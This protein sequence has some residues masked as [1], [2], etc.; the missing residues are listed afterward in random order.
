M[1]LTVEAARELARSLVESAQSRWAHVQAVGRRAEDLCECCE[2]AEHVA[3]AAWLH[4]IGYGPTVVDTGLHA[5]DGA[6]WLERF[7][8]PPEV[9]QLVGW[10]TGAGFEAEERGLTEEHAA[11]P[12]PA[13]RD[14]DALTMLD[15]A[16][17]PAGNPVRDV[18][19]IAEILA[20]YPEG[21]SVHRAVSRARPAL[22]AASGRAKQRLGLPGSWPVA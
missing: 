20:R 8:A 5:L 11:V 22:L 19:R 17:D 14:L 3:V 10:H 12:L 7:D 2:L 15:L 9:V 4:D 18:H 21:H 6:R 1:A 16:T 13:S